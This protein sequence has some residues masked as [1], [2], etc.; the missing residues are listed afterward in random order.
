MPRASALRRSASCSA[1]FSRFDQTISDP[2]SNDSTAPLNYLNDP[3]TQANCIA[4]G[5]PAGATYQQANPQIS[6]RVG[7]NENLKAETSKSW[8]FG[9]VFSPAIFPGLSIEYNH[10]DI[11][12]QD[13]IPV[14]RG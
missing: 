1:R 8:V 2:C 10:Y 13:A 3:T 4:H 6:V 14:L 9:G 7:G 12:I 11:E 5:V